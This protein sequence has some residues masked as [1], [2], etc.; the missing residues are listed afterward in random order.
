MGDSV[1]VHLAKDGECELCFSVHLFPF[2]DHAGSC[3]VLYVVYIMCYFTLQGAS[4]GKCN[5]RNA[6]VQANLV[7]VS[8]SGRA[9]EILVCNV[10]PAA[11]T[12]GLTIDL[13]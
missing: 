8:I 9:H 7:R 5:A 2:G 1:F 4:S 12:V 13:S 3:G 10:I 11:T 6:D